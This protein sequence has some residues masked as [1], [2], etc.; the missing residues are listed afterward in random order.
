M[1]PP[2]GGQGRGREYVSDGTISLE[3]VEMAADDI[4]DM[5]ACGM[6][7]ED[8]GNPITVA[9]GK[10]EAEGGSAGGGSDHLRALSTTVLGNP[11]LRKKVDISE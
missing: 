6:E 10:T 4:L 9:G 7:Y 5:G 8:K 1:A 3:V 2:V 11:W